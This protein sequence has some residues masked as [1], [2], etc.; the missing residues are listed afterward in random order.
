[1][2]LVRCVKRAF[3]RFAPVSLAE[4][5]A[6]KAFFS[7]YHPKE[8]TSDPSGQYRT[9]PRT[10]IR[11]AEGQQGPTVHRPDHRSLRRGH[12][13]RRRRLHRR[14]PPARLPT[15]QE[16][17]PRRSHP[18]LTRPMRRH[19]HRVCT[20]AFFSSRAHRVDGLASK[21]ILAPHRARLGRRR[22]RRLAPGQTGRRW[23]AR[24][25][26]HRRAGRSDTKS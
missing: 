5:W 18:N 3:D 17:H 22:H 15:A 24:C 26:Q 14:L 8:L 25:R 20:V 19:G 23:P 12:R 9:H 7:R 16:S 13:R 21:D 6:S 1:M 2:A 10:G 11:S 4:S